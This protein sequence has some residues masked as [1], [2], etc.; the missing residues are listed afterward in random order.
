M[1]WAQRIA[2][3]ALLVLAL[4]A[5]VAFLARSTSNGSS[6]DT[7]TKHSGFTP[8]SYTRSGDSSSTTRESG[9]RTSASSSTGGVVDG[10]KTVG[11]NELPREAKQTIKLIDDGG[12]FPYAR[13]GVIFGNFEKVLP[14]QPR[15]WY[16]EYTVKT[17][18][19]KNRGARRIITGQDGALYYTADHY[20]SFK[21]VQR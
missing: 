6:N 21:R 7:A 9:N 17:P 19:A 12:P 11:I 14:K 20:Q 5:G 3:I 16:H 8:S 13:D 10:L 2:T 4:I 1:G 15:G 18:G